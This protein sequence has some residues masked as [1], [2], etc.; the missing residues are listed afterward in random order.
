VFAEALARA[1]AAL[2]D[3]LRRLEETATP[4]SAGA[5]EG[6]RGRL[7]ATQAHLLEHFRCEEHD[8]NMGAVRKQ[9]PRLER[10]V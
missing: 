5:L 6:L 1:H 8:G 10:A 7:G 4:T 9:E 3:D 2:L